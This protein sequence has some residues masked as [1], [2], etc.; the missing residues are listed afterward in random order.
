M[1]LALAARPVVTLWVSLVVI[2]CSC[3]RKGDPS[4]LAPQEK[5]EVTVKWDKVFTVSKTVP[6]LQVVVNPLLRR[7]SKIH[8]RVFQSVRDL[9]ADYIRYAT[10]FPYPKLGIAELDPPKDGRT[11]WDFPLID[12][13]TEDFVNANAGHPAIFNFSTVPQWMVKTPEPVPYPADPDQVTWKYLRGTEF[14]DPTFKELADYYGRLVSWYTQRGFTDEYGRRHESG[15]HYKIDYWEVLN[16]VDFEHSLSPE[17]YTRAYDA[18]VESVRKVDPQIKFVGMVLAGTSPNVGLDLDAPAFFQYFLDHK[19]HKPGVPLDMISYHCYVTPT[20]D[21]TMQTAPYAVFEQ[22]DHFLDIV[23][24]IQSIRRRLSPETGTAIDEVGSMTADDVFGKRADPFRPI[25][26]AY[27]NLSGAVYAYIYAQLAR[28]GVEVDGESQL[29]GFPSQYP[30]VSMVDWDTGQPNARFWVLKLIKD[31]FGPG[32]KL[33]ESDS[34]SPYVYAQAFVTPQGERRVLL[35][36]KR[37]RSF[38]VSLPGLSGSEI[39]YVDQS[40]GFQPPASLQVTG[41]Q[42]TLRPYAVAVV[43]MPK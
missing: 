41:N 21:E 26:D 6:T 38:E 31:H 16:E 13:M 1:K 10:W 20:P 22:A 15:H 4:S 40:T 28:F 32:D 30:S 17:T 39:S 35:V 34:H 42:F 29:V 19:N 2:F 9:G 7:G 23:R 18:I 3:S 33:V 5:A 14:R 27:W 25:P 11:S 24:Y 36:N 37:S 12:P 43:K 8:D